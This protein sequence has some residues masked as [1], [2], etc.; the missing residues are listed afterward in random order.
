M[1]PLLSQHKGGVRLHW[2]VA[3]SRRVSGVG[4]PRLFFVGSAEW[5]R[6]CLDGAA[7][8]ATGA[9]RELG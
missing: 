9:A 6:L 7:G 5:Y 3:E 2:A 4:E 8:V 1:G